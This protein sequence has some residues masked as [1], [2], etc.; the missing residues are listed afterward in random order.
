MFSVHWDG[1]PQQF[2]WNGRKHFIE[3]SWGP[4]RIETGW[5]RGDDVRRDY[6]VVETTTGERYWLFQNLM[7]ESWHLHGIFA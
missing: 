1:S 6:Y 4:E 3:R 2:G 5:W 7:D